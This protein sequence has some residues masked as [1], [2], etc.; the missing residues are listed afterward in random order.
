MKTLFSIVIT[1]LFFSL[2]AQERLSNFES[3]NT[4]LNHILVSIEGKSYEVVIGASGAISTYRLERNTRRLNHSRSFDLTNNQVLQ[5]S[6]TLLLRVKEH[7]VLYDF[8]KDTFIEVDFE[9]C[10][11]IQFFFQGGVVNENQFIVAFVN[12]CLGNIYEYITLDLDGNQEYIDVPFTIQR[13][14]YNHV[15]L[16]DGFDYVVWSTKEQVEKLR[17]KRDETDLWEY[18]SMLYFI[19]QG[20]LKVVDLSQNNF[21][22]KTIGAFEQKAKSKFQ[23]VDDIPTQLIIDEGIITVTQWIGPTYNVSSSTFNYGETGIALSE[24]NFVGEY[25]IVELESEVY[26]THLK[27]DNSRDFIFPNFMDNNMHKQYSGNSMFALTPSGAKFIDIDAKEVK[28]I[29]ETQYLNTFTNQILQDKK[30]LYAFKHND[31]LNFLDFSNEEVISL[32]SRYNITGGMQQRNLF[33]VN[34]TL[35]LRNSNHLY[36]VIGDSL[37]QITKGELKTEPF[38][39]YEGPNEYLVYFDEDNNGVTT[40]KTDGTNISTIGTLSSF[41]EPTNSYLYRDGLLAFS[42]ADSW[43]MQ[44]TE[45]G[46]IYYLGDGG[47]NTASFNRITIFDEELFYSNEDSTYRIAKDGFKESYEY[48]NASFYTIDDQLLI[49]HK[50]IGIWDAQTKTFDIKT[51]G[52]LPQNFEEISQISHKDSSILFEYAGR[53]QIYAYKNGTISLLKK[54]DNNEGWFF[55]ANSTQYAVFGAYI[56]TVDSISIDIV[57]KGPSFGNKIFTFPR[58]RVIDIEEIE[59]GIRL[60]CFQFN[61]QVCIIKDINFQT[62]VETNY[63]VQAGESE[64]QHIPNYFTFKDK[65]YIAT[66]ESIYEKTSS[67]LKKAETVKLA[68]GRLPLLFLDD[69]IYY[70]GVDR[71]KGDQLYR[72]NPESPNS[73]KPTPQIDKIANL[74]PNPTSGQLAIANLISFENVRIVNAEGRVFYSDIFR[75]SSISIDM[76]D[77]PTGM[78]FVQLT[79][80]SGMVESHKI[81]KI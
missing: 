24:A 7:L 35:F 40:K 25:L 6:N 26:C 32:S 69:Y 71:Y 48:S 74:F 18:E 53:D 47:F 78:Y 59:D 38:I 8:I 5:N 45:D 29:N 3:D 17:L 4:S 21:D 55:L 34:N 65:D 62:G 75:Q 27:G 70:I 67:G 56:N 60:Y 19:E 11:D 79:N 72:Y 43:F 81:I 20:K 12:K 42:E 61:G 66:G 54:D 31:A 9:A 46:L 14:L 44:N 77:W 10:N 23:L 22:P 16:V 37:I 41:F 52:L 33:E 13:T 2:S 57:K 63:F 49:Y 36:Q 15:I 50:G 39:G 73:V 1:V 28:S 68:W 58:L 51:F 64:F 30:G 76:V 80:K